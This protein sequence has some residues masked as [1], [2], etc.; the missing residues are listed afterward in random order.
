MLDRVRVEF[1]NQVKLELGSLLT[2]LVSIK[3]ICGRTINILK[4]QDIRIMKQEMGDGSWS[5]TSNGKFNS[6]H[7]PQGMWKRIWKFQVLHK[8]RSFIIIWLIQQHEKVFT[9]T[10]TERIYLTA[11]FFPMNVEDLHHIFR[12]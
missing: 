9:N 8:I 7:P 6:C 11:F 4:R 5:R 10:N 2:R 3:H 12:S 1:F